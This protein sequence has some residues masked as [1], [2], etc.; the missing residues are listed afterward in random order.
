MDDLFGDAD[1]NTELLAAPGPV[2][3]RQNVVVG[4]ASWADPS[5]VKSKRFYP[6]GHSAPEKM[7]RYYASQFPMVEVDSSFFAMRSG[8]SARPTTSGSI[9]SRSGYS[10]A[11]RR[12]PTSSRRTS[13][14]R[15][16]R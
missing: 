14:R 7:L 11:I 2:G 15:C 3:P 10:P 6:K 16:R 12:H 1:P 9:S 4:M 8:S 13:S 5:L